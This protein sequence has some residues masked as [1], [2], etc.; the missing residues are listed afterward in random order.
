MSVNNGRGAMTGLI[1]VGLIGA[2][3]QASRSPAMHME[4][5]RALG[6]RVQYELLDL[7]TLGGAAALGELLRRLE[8][9]AFAGV[10]VTH[11]CKQSVLAHLQ[12]LSPEASLIGAVNTV[13]F[14]RGRR[15]GF[16]TDWIGFAESVRRR[17]ADAALG[18]VAQLGAGGA[19]CA[20]VYALL[21]CG[22]GRVC[23]YDTDAARAEDLA[24]RFA[25]Q[26]DPGRV[27][28]TRD[29]TG[30]LAHSDG[31]VNASP[32]GMR[33]HPGMPLPRQLLRPSL[34]VADI[35]YFPLE[36]EL[37]RAARSL[38]CRAFDGGTMAVLQAA[39]AF[40]LFTGAEPEAERMLA[41][42]YG[43]LSDT[44]AG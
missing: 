34:W 7:D 42:F 8:D 1:K 36:T 21:T 4:E 2:G 35:V 28:A 5:A 22:A 19:G 32:V 24:N 30:S 43:S 10:N 17:L 12:E 31:L 25:R 41:R 40:R 23:V 9:D 13:V 44:A 29:L 26:F 20:T 16:N 38:G 39:A 27:V 37:L 11:P 3:I 33:S 6:I 14:D 18:Q 15:V